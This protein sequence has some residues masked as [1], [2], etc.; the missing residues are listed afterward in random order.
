MKSKQ[1]HSTRKPRVHGLSRLEKLLEASIRQEIAIKRLK[2]DLCA[3][4]REFSWD[5]TYRDGDTIRDRT[6]KLWT[7]RAAT[8]AVCNDI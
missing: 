6:G 3:I 2:R 8:P 7:V 1:T 5:G 4:S